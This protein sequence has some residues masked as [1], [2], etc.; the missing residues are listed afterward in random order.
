MRFK[1]GLNAFPRVSNLFPAPPNAEHDAKEFG[2]G[3]GSRVIVIGLIGDVKVSF[4]F[5]FWLKIVLFEIH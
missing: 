2:M 3:G 5:G 4:C 1:V